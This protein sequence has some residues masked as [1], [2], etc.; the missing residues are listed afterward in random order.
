MKSLTFDRLREF[1]EM[2]VQDPVNRIRMNAVV[3]SGL[4]AAATNQQEDIDNPMIFSTELKTGKVTSQNSSGRCWLTDLPDVLGQ[5]REVEFLFGEHRQHGQGAAGR[6]I[7]RVH[8]VESDS[9]W[10]S[11]GHVLFLG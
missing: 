11:V 9:R 2:F 3:K 10:R 6:P 1:S 7:G 5:G 4:N 8:L